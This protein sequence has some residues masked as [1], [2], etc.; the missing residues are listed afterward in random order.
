M[1]RH[2]D[3]RALA[4]GCLA[5]AACSVGPDYRRPTLPVPRAYAG[6]GAEASDGRIDPTWWRLFGDDA[7][8]S[9][10]QRALAGNPGLTSALAR[11]AEA[12]AVSAQGAGGLYP[13]VTLGATLTRSHSL[14]TGASGGTVLAMPFDLSYELDIWGR[15]RR[16]VEASRAQALSSADSYGVALLSLTANVATTYFMQRSLDSQADVLARS[17]ESFR[18]QLALTRVKRD[19]ALV[20][21]PDVL[22]AQTQLDATLAQQADVERQRID[23]EHA[24]A[25]LIGQPPSALALPPRPLAGDPPRIP[26]GVPSTLLRRRPDVAAGEQALVAAS[27]SIGAARASLYPTF[28]LTGSAGV[29]SAA[30]TGPLGW[31]NRTWSV[32][33]GLLAPIFDGGKLRAQVEQARGAYDEALGNYRAAML[34]ALA[35][36]ENGLTDIGHLQDSGA[37]YRRAADAARENLRLTQL[38]YDQGLVDYLS[39]LDAQRTWLSDELLAAQTLGQRYVSTVL[40]IKALGG[41]WTVDDGARVLNAAR[42]TGPT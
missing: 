41:G 24:L 30:L 33:G 26:A 39:V 13:T 14:P 40:L 36:V 27:A 15:V 37:A 35:D 7:L 20:G 19:A 32:G 10:E 6:A 12:R 2:I 23:A 8:S 5:L 3:R 21:P 17:V 34:Q 28:S 9:L 31:A 38:Q 18:K 11:V 1:K 22:Q 4:L 16:T 25:I 29:A 42:A